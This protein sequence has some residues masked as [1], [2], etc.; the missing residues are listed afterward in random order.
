MNWL[1]IFKFKRKDVQRTLI[2]ETF[3][4]KSTVRELPPIP[5]NIVQASKR[6][7]QTLDSMK[8]KPFEKLRLIYAF[9]DTF[10]KFASTFSVCSKACS[11]CCKIDVHVT[12]LEAKYLEKHSD[13]ILSKRT[14]KIKTHNRPCPFLQNDICTVYDARPFNCCTLFTLDDPKYC[15]TNEQHQTYGACGGE[16]VKIIQQLRHYVN[17]LNSTKGAGDIRFYFK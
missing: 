12:T 14:G 17:H 11:E 2:P 7:Q 15:S 5:D 1:N 8:D 6:L 10:N 13:A 9:L 16:S 3:L 4:D